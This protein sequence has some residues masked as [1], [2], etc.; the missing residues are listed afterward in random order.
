MPRL[1]APIGSSAPAAA[2]PLLAAV[3]RQLGS[4]PNLFPLLASNPAALE[5][6]LGLNGALAVAEFNGGN[7]RLSAHACLGANLARLSD[8]EIELNRAGGSQDAKANAG[9]RLARRIV[10]TR[11]RVSDA[12]IGAARAAGFSDA[13]IFEI[14]ACVAVNV[15]T[16]DLKNVVETAIDFPIVRVAA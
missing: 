15:F 16:N 6:S 10:D 11:G 9:V 14:T 5:G 8:T 2:E 4:T 3:E 12:E 1:A 7:Y 13:Q